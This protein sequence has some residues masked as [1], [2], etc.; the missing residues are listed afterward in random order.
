MLV[1]SSHD[2]YGSLIDRNFGA[3]N[4]SLRTSFIANT[5][6]CAGACGV[7]GAILGLFDPGFFLREGRRTLCR[8]GGEVIGSGWR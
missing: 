3:E 2:L 7:Y 1:L 6:W 5:S 4:Y 8:K